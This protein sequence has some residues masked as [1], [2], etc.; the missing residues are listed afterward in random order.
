[1]GHCRHSSNFNVEVFDD[2]VPVVEV[3]MVDVELFVVVVGTSTRGAKKLCHMYDRA[4]ID[5][6]LHFLRNRRGPSCGRGRR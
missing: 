2:V 6:V 1:M 3:L 5:D 4:A